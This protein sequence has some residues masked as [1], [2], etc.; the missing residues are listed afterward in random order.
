M[1]VGQ[2]TTIKFKAAMITE[3]ASALMWG[4]RDDDFLTLRV[5]AEFT[6]LAAVLGYR[7]EKIKADEVAE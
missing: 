4:S 1:D 7:I 6:Q 2:S 5:Y 3:Y